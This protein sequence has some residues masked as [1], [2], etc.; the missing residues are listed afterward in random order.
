[1]IPGR[2]R[3]EKRGQG[4]GIDEEKENIEKETMKGNDLKGLIPF[5]FA[6]VHF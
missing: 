4:I 5:S 1:L 6:L 3:F 2:L